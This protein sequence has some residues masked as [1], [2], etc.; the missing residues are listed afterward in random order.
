MNAS[1]DSLPRQ[2]AKHK[3]WVGG[4]HHLGP[5]QSE[6]PKWRGCRKF[7]FD[8][9]SS[10]LPT[11]SAESWYQKVWLCACALGTGVPLSRPKKR[12]MIARVLGH[13]HA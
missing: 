1:A 12:S 7:Q 3:F 6:L 10:W 9:L 8:I 2:L 4:S 11:G 13:Q 5:V